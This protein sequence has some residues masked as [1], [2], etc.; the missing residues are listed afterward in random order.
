MKTPL[1]NPGAILI[2]QVDGDWVIFDNDGKEWFTFPVVLAEDRP[3]AHKI[4]M[5]IVAAINYG[6]R[7]GYEDG[8]KQAQRNIAGSMGIILPDSPEHD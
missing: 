8:Y 3:T 4:S 2:D 1:I 5:I 7:V 6:A